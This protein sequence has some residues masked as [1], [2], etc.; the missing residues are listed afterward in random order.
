MIVGSHR[1]ALF[2]LAVV[3]IVGILVAAA[4]HGLAAANPAE[5]EVKAAYVYNFGRFV[6][7]P[8]GMP[9]SQVDEFPIC[10]L[11]RD[12]F[13]T[14]LDATISGEK[15]NCTHV[16]ARRI[17]KVEESG[18]CRVRFIGSSEDK[19]LKDILSS[20][21]KLY[22]LTVSDLPRFIQQGGMV[23]FVMADRRVRFEINLAAAQQAGLKLSSEL[24]KVAA[25][26]TGVS[27]MGN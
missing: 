26:V 14:A 7:W 20:V 16:V 8:T 22:V 1:T 3:A 12:R 23:Q 17:P 19:Q 10:V 4:G 9:P 5:Y 21:S 27:R 25:T 2:R 11:D 15:L 18:S 6:E 24:L 13:G